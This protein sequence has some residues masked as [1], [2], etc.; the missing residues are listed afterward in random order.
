MLTGPTWARQAIG[1]G[2][3]QREA[4]KRPTRMR[5][6]G[7]LP[8]FAVLQLESYAIM[9]RRLRWADDATTMQDFMTRMVSL[10]RLYR[11]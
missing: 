10:T 1:K 3:H 4:G 5:E 11:V 2:G 9:S 6:Q 7:R 8:T